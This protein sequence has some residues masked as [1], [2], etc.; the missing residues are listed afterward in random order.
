MKISLVDKPRSDGILSRIS[1]GGQG[2]KDSSLNRIGQG[3]STNT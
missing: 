3:N 1:G 2:N